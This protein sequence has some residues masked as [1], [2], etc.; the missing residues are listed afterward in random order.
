MTIKHKSYNEKAKAF[1]NTAG[2]CFR[3]VRVYEPGVAASVPALH[4]HERLSPSFNH[5]GPSLN[6]YDAIS[7]NLNLQ[8]RHEIPGTV[9]ETR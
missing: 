8:A 9:Y 1:L 6:S 2:S 4:L 7:N 5:R 3:A